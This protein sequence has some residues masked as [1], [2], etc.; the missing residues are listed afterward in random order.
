MKKIILLFLYLCVSIGMF[1]QNKR[2]VFSDAPLRVGDD[3]Q[4]RNKEF[5]EKDWFVVQL[6]R[7]WDS[8]GFGDY[9]G[10]AFYRKRFNL[11]IEMLE[12]SH[13]KDSLVFYMGQIDDADEVY[14][15]GKMIGKTGRFP[16][17]KGG[18]LSAAEIERRYHVAAN[19]PVVKWGEENVLAIRVY[20][21]EGLGGMI[22]GGFPY[23]RMIDLMDELSIETFFSKSEKGKH[24]CSVSI[25]NGHNISI[26]GNLK[27]EVIDTEVNSVVNNYSRNLK[28]G[29][30][31]I[32]SQVIPYSP[33]KRYCIRTTFV[34][35]KTG[36]SLVDNEI[37]PY[38]LTPPT[39][40][41]PRIN[42][43]KVFGVRPGSP[44]FFKIP[45]SG[46][47][48]M[49]YTVENL[50]EGLNVNSETGLI[51][52]AVQKAGE[53][54]MTFIAQN[55]LGKVSREFTLKVGEQL[56]LTPP[57]GWN[58]WNC[59]GITVSDEK[60][61]KSAQALLDRGLI[62]FGWMY[63][64]V[65]DAWQNDKRDAQGMLNP[66]GRFPDM[67]ALG[68]WLHANGLRFGIYSSPG[69]YTCG[70]YLGSWEFERKDADTWAS[71]GVDYLKYDWCGYHE[72][73][74]RDNEHSLSAHM[75]PYMK[76]AADLKAQKRDIVYS[77]CQYGYRE[78][79]QW[80][81]A[82]GGNLWRSTHDIVD[83]W[84][85]IKLIGFDLQA[86]LSHFAGPGHWND[87]DM[88]VV[89]QLGW[90]SK[91]RP[92]RLSYDEQYTHMSL[93]SLLSAPLL[94]GCDL[95]SLDDFTMNLLTNA[96]VIAV[97]QD[98]LGCQAEK[99]IDKGDM[100]VWVKQLEDGSRAVG[101]F[102]LG[103]HDQEMEV[104]FHDLNLPET[105]M[106]R[107]IWKQKD[108]G[109]STISFTS[110]IPSHGVMLLK[111]SQ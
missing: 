94:L 18:F 32:Y 48:P 3:P 101:V 73:Y 99:L 25:K 23:V 38:V 58:S 21:H 11:P 2:I 102:N 98:P 59:W 65:D 12:Q 17:D 30:K 105:V 55:K 41:T 76:M 9:D 63:I 84:E 49:K 62:D 106:V 83:T 19:D 14:L 42:G 24:K 111:I 57:M 51:T 20:D 85:A 89:G 10:I 75:K 29:A 15:N 80:G 5:N 16:N 37:V 72:I 88:L 35:K 64:N 43:A 60:V 6:N 100:Q 91:L 86:P 71:W 44:F 81:E 50:P 45:A 33:N 47:K 109:K 52:G 4:W 97:N 110:R 1:T 103:D 56:C 79:W 90:G 104:K 27:I 31:D 68:D 26:S 34:E 67:K 108:L 54:R 40:K 74:T 69:P 13:W 66:N 46:C 22:S 61:K 92:T 95:N 7:D 78:V 36:L 28:L 8:Q 82:A 39:P 53:Y 87:P 107:D 96:E 70:K 93:W 77:L